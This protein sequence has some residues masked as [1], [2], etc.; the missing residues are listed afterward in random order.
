MRSRL[1][2]PLLL[3]AACAGQ[4]PK[5]QLVSITPA[6]NPVVGRPSEGDYVSAKAAIAQAEEG[7][8]LGAP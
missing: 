7:W 5:A 4:P 3:L 1:V 2:L 8:I 6:Q